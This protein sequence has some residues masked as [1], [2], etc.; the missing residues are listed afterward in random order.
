L[1]VFQQRELV[2]LARAVYFVEPIGVE[3][4]EVRRVQP[5]QCLLIAA[6]AGGDEVIER[7]PGVA[8]LV[9]E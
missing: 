3:P 7:W 5:L 1:C 6:C 8:A 2:G 9:E 4:V